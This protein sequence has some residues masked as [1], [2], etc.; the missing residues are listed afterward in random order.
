MNLPRKGRP[1]DHRIDRDVT[2]A[3]L[4]LVEEVGFDRFSVEEVA[5]R[6]G[7]AKT[8]VYR[9]FPTRNDLLA[10][11]LERLNDDV[12]PAPADWSTHDR[13]VAMLTFLR[14]RKSDA[15]SR[16]RLI[17][18]AATTCRDPELWAIV[19]ERVLGPRRAALRGV[20]QDGIERGELRGDLDL[21][22]AVAILAGAMFYLGVADQKGETGLPTVDA[23][24][25][26][27]LAGLAVRD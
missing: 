17:Q 12:S 15:Q 9:R 7:V 3:A 8:T 19:Q 1:R 24:V 20:L 25:R 16:D 18:V 4:D 5:A 2:S 10:G 13:L 23:T 22:V 6:A 26:C 27:A 14:Q 11:V 21:D